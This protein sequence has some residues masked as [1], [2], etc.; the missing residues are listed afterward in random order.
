MKTRFSLVLLTWVCSIMALV[1]AC[2]KPDRCSKWDVPPPS[3]F[4]FQIEEEGERLPDRI[5]AQVKCYYLQGSTR[6]YVQ[7]FYSDSI[8]AEYISNQ[9]FL[10]DRAA[11]L[12][13]SGDK[14]VRD[15]FVEFPDGTVDSLYLEVDKVDLCQA[16][17]EMCYCNYPI[18][19]VRY[20][21]VEAEEHE[22]SWTQGA[23]L[24]IFWR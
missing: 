7:L 1:N 3:S 10:I 17:Q 4:A 16:K 20:N 23:P 21:G 14:G 9:G 24:Y 11:M 15:F 22:L 19:A 2:N 5:V 13:V 12:R 8:L 6:K 18:R